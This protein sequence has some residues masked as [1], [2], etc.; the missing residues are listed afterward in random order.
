MK[1]GDVKGAGTDANVSCLLFGQSPNTQTDKLPLKL[2]MSHANKF[3]EGQVDVFNLDA[4]DV[5][6]L[7]KIKICKG[8]LP[9]EFC[10]QYY[11]HCYDNCLCFVCLF[12]CGRARPQWP[13]CQLVP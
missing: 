1:T 13:G 11:C 4:K 7:K 6:R 2:S 12:V 3:E 9:L 10:C 8:T 5:G